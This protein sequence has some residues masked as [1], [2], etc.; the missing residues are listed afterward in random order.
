MVGGAQGDSGVSGIEGGADL[1]SGPDDAAELL[2]AENASA[3]G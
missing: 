3:E 2:R 1:C